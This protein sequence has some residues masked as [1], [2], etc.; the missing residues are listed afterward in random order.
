MPDDLFQTKLLHKIEIL[1]GGHTGISIFIAFASAT[2]YCI[3]FPITYE[4]SLMCMHEGLPK[5]S[6]LILKKK[7]HNTININ[8]QVCE[9]SKASC[10]YWS[11][12]RNASVLCFNCMSLIHHATF[13]PA[14]STRFPPAT[15][16]LLYFLLEY[17]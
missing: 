11:L 4:R 6:V 13:P 5:F 9:L 15:L 8:R 10:F 16:V 2:T 1:Y 3:L 7:T 12:R 14:F 17:F